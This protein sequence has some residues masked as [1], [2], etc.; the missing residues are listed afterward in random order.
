MTSTAMPTR[1]SADA[2]APLRSDAIEGAARELRGAAKLLLDAQELVVLRDAIGAARR[3]GL[4]L[5]GSRRDG[6]VGDERVFRLTRPVRDDGEISRRTRHLDRL[7]RFAQRADL[8]HFD[9]NRVADTILDATRETLGIRHE[10]IVAD[11]LAAIAKRRR[12]LRPTGPIVFGESI[13]DRHDR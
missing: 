11:E 10:Q 9:Q 13:F 6:E 4:D 7:E 2:R 8:V 3:A 5:S 12:E 1:F